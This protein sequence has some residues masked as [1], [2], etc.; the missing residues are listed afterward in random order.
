MNEG[1][2]EGKRITEDLPGSNRD[3]KTFKGKM[4]LTE[5]INESPKRKAERKEKKRKKRKTTKRTESERKRRKN[6]ENKK[7]YGHSENAKGK[8]V[9]N[10][11]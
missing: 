11:K 8:D 4:V 5:K 7:E 9:R 3:H 2:K 6:D 1:K 10:C